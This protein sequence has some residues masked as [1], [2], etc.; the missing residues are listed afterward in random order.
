MFPARSIRRSMI[1]LVVASIVVV[2]LPASVRPA[3]AAQATCTT[4][5]QSPQVW[6]AFCDGGSSVTINDAGTAS[7]YPS[8]LEVS[9]LPGVIL[10][11]NVFLVGLTHERPDDIDVVLQGPDGTSSILMSD[12]GGTYTAS[13]TPTVALRLDDTMAGVDG[14][15]QPY[16]YPF[17]PDNG[18][19]P[20]DFA[21][22]H[23]TNATTWG[24]D[25]DPFV[26]P[27]PAPSLADLRGF[28]G[29]SPNGAW[30]L[31]IVDDESPF[32]GELSTWWLQFVLWDPLAPTVQQETFNI[33][34][35]LTPPPALLTINGGN[36]YLLRDP[37]S[38]RF[39][40]PDGAGPALGATNLPNKYEG[41]AT[42][43]GVPRSVAVGDWDRGDAPHATGP[44]DGQ[45]V[46]VVNQDGSVELLDDASSKSPGDVGGYRRL[47]IWQKATGAAAAAFLNWDA[48]A[49]G[50][51]IVLVTH[52][53]TGDWRLDFYSDSA[54]WQGPGVLRAS[55]RFVDLTDASGTPYPWPSGSRVLDVVRVPGAD[56]ELI[57]AVAIPRSASQDEL[58]LVRLRLLPELPRADTIEW[59]GLA[60]LGLVNTVQAADVEAVAEPGNR[61]VLAVSTAN[62]TDFHSVYGG[63]LVPSTNWAVT[64]AFAGSCQRV[65]DGRP[66]V[67]VAPARSTTGAGTVACATTADGAS[68]DA[69][70]LAVKS[71]HM[72]SASEEQVQVSE[73]KGDILDPTVH[74]L[75]RNANTAGQTLTPPTALWQV[76]FI[77]VEGTTAVTKL[78]FA[79]VEQS[80]D[81]TSGTPDRTTSRPT[82][83]RALPTSQ[84]AYVMAP[85]DL[86]A[87]IVKLVRTGD[88]TVVELTPIP[89]IVLAAPPKVSGLGQQT[90]LAP[91]YTT[92]V[93]TGTGT[94]DSTETVGSVI[95]RVSVRDPAFDAGFDAEARLSAGIGWSKA[96]NSMTRIED[97]YIGTTDEDTVVVN[98]STMWKVPYRIAESSDGLGVGQPID[99]YAPRTTVLAVDTVSRLRDTAPELFGMPGDHGVPIMQE[100]D[101]AT[102]LPHEPETRPPTS[103]RGRSG[104]TAADRLSAR[105]LTTSSREARRR[106]DRGSRSTP[107]PL[108]R[109]RNRS[110]CRRST[111][112]ARSSTSAW[113]CPGPVGTAG[114]R[115]P[116]RTAPTRATSA[117]SRIS[118]TGGRR[119]TPGGW[120]SASSAWAHSRSG[121]RNTRLTTTRDAAGSDPWARSRPSRLAGTSPCR[122]CPP[123]SGREAERSASTSLMSA[124]RRGPAGSWPR[125]RCRRHQTSGIRPC[126][127][128]RRPTMRPTVSS[129]G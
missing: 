3:S 51:D 75:T 26:P 68:P 101:W 81:A 103:T 57:A 113:A 84:T 80:F 15:G 88:R 25:S 41:L 45:E 67:A 5:L 4:E 16:Y 95:F 28:N 48:T 107:R 32:A 104:A 120:S 58:R 27:A 125:S 63:T 79:G 34:Q 96:T 122:R 65:Q 9:G 62:G 71:W 52:D 112:P 93:V 64:G 94:G 90:A 119:P 128:T 24:D 123:S 78:R 129:R 37:A 66:G 1:A 61:V 98:R 117:T 91:A 106:R 39:V 115:P 69:Q 111:W 85:V 40:D 70:V 92:G 59:N 46:L 2:G 121:R 35:G 30:R 44:S 87:P 11:V 31:Y 22:R 17:L 83:A 86:A 60:Y 18:P 43:D 55:I 97:F 73:I 47:W 42:L 100:S 13:A 116:G 7:P 23:T 21:A 36:R 14:S 49:A 108:P 38:A 72:S 77:S 82:P 114:S 127:A 29:V 53:A 105:S 12:V 124:G 33:V 118:L 54:Y 89:Q 50:D 99:I 19:L 10:D 76:G 110:G 6:G 126:R 8:T 20:T 102:V 56:K 109:I 74:F